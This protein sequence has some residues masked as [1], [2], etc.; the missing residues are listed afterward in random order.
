MWFRMTRK[1]R[2]IWVTALCVALAGIALGFALN[3]ALGGI[4]ASASSLVM[5]FTSIFAPPDP[6][7]PR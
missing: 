5:I 6:P 3:P 1:Q 2:T 4:I 7:A